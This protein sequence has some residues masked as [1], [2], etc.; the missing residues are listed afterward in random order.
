MTLVDACFDLTSGV[1]ELHYLN[2]E[3]LIDDVEFHHAFREYFGYRGS[4]SVIKEVFRSLD[5]DGSGEIGFDELFEVSTFSC[6]MRLDTSLN[7]THATALFERAYVLGA[8]CAWQA[9]CP[10]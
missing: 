5:T 7:A 2:S 9:P 1:F 10:R 8:V 4:P 3:M 6:H